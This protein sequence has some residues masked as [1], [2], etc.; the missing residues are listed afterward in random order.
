MADCKFCKVPPIEAAKTAVWAIDIPAP[1]KQIYLR[2]TNIIYQKFNQDEFRTMS[3]FSPHARLTWSLGEAFQF[4]A[5]A[6]A[7]TEFIAGPEIHCIIFDKSEQLNNKDLSMRLENLTLPKDWDVVFI[8]ETQYLMT[9]R[10]ATIY[11]NSIQQ[12]H[13]P[14]KTYLRT[15]DILR[16]VDL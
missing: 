7:W 1:E 11:A 13:L 15:F 12:F 6:Q 16:V 14:L 4:M 5:H 9:K 3:R 8:S 10:A 2:Y